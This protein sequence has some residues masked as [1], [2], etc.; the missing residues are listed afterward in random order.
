MFLVDQLLSTA[1]RRCYWKSY[2]PYLEQSWGIN[3]RVNSLN[4]WY[5]ETNYNTRL[6]R[7]C[8]T[9]VYSLEEYCFQIPEISNLTPA[10]DLHQ[11]CWMVHNIQ[12]PIAEAL[13]SVAEALLRGCGASA[14]FLQKKS[15]L[16]V[17][18]LEFDKKNMFYRSLTFAQ[19][20]Q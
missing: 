16:L 15:Q 20:W 2:N 12:H 19:V 1:R 14:P 6:G 7:Q 13:P 18:S 5:G 8:Q 11:T 9:P 4:E 3:K 10:P 17:L